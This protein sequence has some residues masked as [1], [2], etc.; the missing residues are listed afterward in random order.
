MTDSI[1]DIDSIKEREPEDI[2][3]KE[4]SDINTKNKIE[5]NTLYVVATPI[6]NLSDIT[7]RAID[8]LKGVDFI[9]AEDTRHASIL[10]KH[11]NIKKELVVYYSASSKVRIEQCIKRIENGE[12]AA[13]ISDAGT[14]CISDPGVSLLA[15]AIKTS[16]SIVPIP[17]VS[18][19]TTLLSVAGIAV[20]PF[21]FAGFLSNKGGTRRNQLTALFENEKKLIVLY[22]SVHRIE[23]F[24]E[25]I[26]NV[27]GEDTYIILGRE[28]TKSFEQ[29][30]RD[31]AKNI[32][33]FIK[34]RNIIC[35]GEFCII[36]DNNKQK[37][38][39]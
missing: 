7:Y 32:L 8:V 2:D 12:S 28:L 21:V 1:E 26:V 3:G 13:L 33:A 10:L 9:M 20:S 30:V 11:Y 4:D 38:K 29:I 17:G 15:Q 19:I 6:G 36:I 39:V 24:I 23:A 25:D 37:P 34:N 18:A 31:N 27:F 14:P 35:K 22:E 16:I 5:N